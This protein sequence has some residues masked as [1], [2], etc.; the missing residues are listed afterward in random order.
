MAARFCHA[1]VVPVLRFSVSPD[2]TRWALISERMRH[3]DLKRYLVDHGRDLGA[4]ERLNILLGAAK[5]LAYL[6]TGAD[7]LTAVNTARGA[8]AAASFGGAGW[9]AGAGAVPYAP[10]DPVA[11]RD[12]TS[13]NVVLDDHNV[14]RL[15]DLGTSKV[16]VGRG[17]Y[18][19]AETR[20]NFTVSTP[21]YRA[22][23]VDTGRVSLKTDIFGFGVIMLEMLTGRP[24]VVD[25][26]GEKMDLHRVY[27]RKMR[28][29]AVTTAMADTV[30]PEGVATSLHRLALLCTEDHQADRPTSRRIVAELLAMKGDLERA[31]RGDVLQPL[32]EEHREDMLQS[33]LYF[34]ADAQVAMGALIAGDGGTGHRDVLQRECVLCSTQWFESEMLSCLAN[35]VVCRECL[36]AHASS[37]VNSVDR[38][39]ASGFVFRCPHDGCDVPLPLDAMSRVLSDVQQN[40]VHRGVIAMAA[41]ALDALALSDVEQERLRAVGVAHERAAQEFQELTVLG[42]DGVKA[43]LKRSQATARQIRLRRNTEVLYHQTHRG[44][45]DLI[46]GSGRFMPGSHGLAGGGIYFA[47]SPEDTVGKA[48][49]T[50]VM[51]KCRV[52]LGNVLQLTSD[53][54]RTMNTKKLLAGGHDSVKIGRTRPEW[55]VYVHS[56]VEIVDSY[57]CDQRTG[58]RL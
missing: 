13:S 34:C 22:P 11:H 12:I 5:G 56:Q 53:G 38:M 30:W 28:D 57:D 54:D 29:T 3:G 46:L 32:S 36:A 14:A 10:V 2:G 9:P 26:R 25:D 44:A 15:L 33:L 40:E 48:Q 21:G 18:T 4:L 31:E 47:A 58:A 43:V 50:G 37:V 52:Q 8:G 49:S 42:L 19:Q 35:H 27:R 6:H 23:E 24:P 41:A 1:H 55:V 16:L 20:T 39:K 51:F 7:H 17:A 45:A